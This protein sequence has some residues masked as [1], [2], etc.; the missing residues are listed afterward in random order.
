MKVEYTHK[1]IIKRYH[2][3][4]LVDK[5]HSTGM[6]MVIT[7][8]PGEDVHKIRRAIQNVYVVHKQTYS[9]AMHTEVK[10]NV[11]TAWFS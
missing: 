3:K 1:P 8:E 2:L 9:C 4:P 11:I 5:A 10:G 7:A 6:A